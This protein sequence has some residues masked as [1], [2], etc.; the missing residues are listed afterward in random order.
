MFRVVYIFCTKNNIRYGVINYY[1]RYVE[2]PPL[3]EVVVVQ[4]SELPSEP[5]E[6]TPAQVR[7][8]VSLSAKPRR[9]PII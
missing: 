1:R 7:S 6:L 5:T 4:L 2:L 3:I 9:G 8:P